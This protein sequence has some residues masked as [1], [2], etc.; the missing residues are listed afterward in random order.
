MGESKAN[1]PSAHSEQCWATGPPRGVA[2][3]V[4]GVYR[5]EQGSPHQ[6]SKPHSRDMGE[7]SREGRESP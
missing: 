1:R 3:A 5:P 2:G 7:P 4:T 6:E